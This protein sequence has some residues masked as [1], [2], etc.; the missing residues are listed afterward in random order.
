MKRLRS[1]RT[2]PPAERCLVVR[3]ALL[4]GVMRLGLRLLP[5]RA[6][7]RLLN[8][9][10][11]VPLALPAAN[12]FSPDRI[13]WAVRVA[14]P[15]VIGSKPCLV[16]SLTVHLL[17]RRRGYPARLHLGVARGEGGRV[18]AHAWVASNDRVVIGGSASDLQRYTLLLALD[19]ET[20]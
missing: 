8:R 4:L 5:F 14:S 3:A 17:L 19:A 15:H 10:A 6:L 12:D 16:Q 1:F 20:A 18:E 2:L 9:A 7:W 13:A 11:R